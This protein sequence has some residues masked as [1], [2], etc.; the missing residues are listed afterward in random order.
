M[1]VPGIPSNGYS[2][3]APLPAPEEELPIEVLLDDPDN[4]LADIAEP[5]API[6]FDANLAEHL[7]DDELN[8]IVL[9]LADA[10]ESDL[11]SRKDWENIY[12]KGLDLLGIKVDDRDYPWAGA[13]GVTHPMILESSVRFQSKASVRLFPAKGPAAVKVYG[14]QDDETLAAAQRVQNDL[15]FYC[16]EKMPEYFPDTEQLLLALPIAGSAFRKVYHDYALARPTACFIKADDFIMPAGFPHLETCPRYTHRLQASRLDVVRLQKLGFYR[17]VELD[18]PESVELSEAAEKE[19][20]LTGLR[21]ATNHNEL[22]PILEMHTALDLVDTPFADETA[23][24]PLPYVVTWEKRSQTVLSIRRNWREDDPRQAKIVHFIHYRYVPGLDNYGWGLIHLIGGITKSST[25]ILRQLVDA[26]TL[27]N[28]P[29]GLKARSLRVKGGDQP[30]AP[31][32]WRDCDLPGGKISDSLLP[33]PY[34]EPSATLLSLYNQLVQEGKEFA[35]IADLDISAASANAPV[36]TI[37]AL[38]ER[39][40]E[41]IAAVQAR[42][43]QAFKQELNLLYDCIKRYDSENG[44]DYPVEGVEPSQKALDYAR[45]WAIRPQSDPSASTTAQRVMQLQAA[46]N[47][48]QQ[49][50]QIYDIPKLHRQ[51]LSTLGV[52]PPEELVPDMKA[53]PLDPVSENMAMINS[54]PVKAFEYQDHTAH[55]AVHQSGKAD[56]ELQA[57]L[58]QSQ[59]GPAVTAAFDAHIAEH[60][61]FQYRSQLEKQLGVPMPPLGEPL[62]PEVEVQVSVL[63]AQAAA[64][65]SAQKASEA[66]QKKAQEQQQDPLFQL[67]KQRADQEGQRIQQEGAIAKAELQLKAKKIDS[68]TQAAGLKAQGEVQKIQ[69][70]AAQ[71]QANAAK[72]A[73]DAQAKQADTALKRE[74]ATAKVVSDNR[75]ID[76]DTDRLTLDADKTDDAALAEGERLRIEGERLRLENERLRAEVLDMRGQLALDRKRIAVQEEQVDVQREQ[77]QGRKQVDRAQA[78]IAAAKQR[79]DDRD[80]KRQAQLQEK[81]IRAQAKQAKQQAAA[82][83]PKEGKPDA[84]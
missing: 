6:P 66:Q 13:C 47:F 73:A 77:V 33:L 18:D 75:R 38:L 65:L 67:E 52:E 43:H 39:A 11:E 60:M 57:Q 46:M 53:E 68:D 69:G 62:P 2:D 31:G 22:L 28:L 36:G 59:T 40:S 5:E 58:S 44:Y 27:S 35:S 21:P 23:N 8:T 26:G 83:A 20:K 51:M 45:R 19:A 63:E 82:P 4:P 15:N 32:E 49:A 56:P 50:P 9:D 81:Q 12:T 24:G 76:L 54:K 80:A 70:Q 10:F 42:L 29:G 30:I 7:T 34:K 37:L 78:A 48:S 41:V 79:S 84:K 74:V 61:A 55:L 16:V 1:I 3:I 71:I 72:T 17:E 25:S 14:R 64:K